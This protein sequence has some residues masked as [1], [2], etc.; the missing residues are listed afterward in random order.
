M[1]AFDDSRLEDADALRDADAL[2]RP[3]AEAGARLRRAV[4]R[5]EVPL[6]GLRA[7]DL[8]RAVIAFGPE[9]RLL[10]A[11]LEPS[12]PVPFV[13]WPRLGLPG[14]AGALDTVVALGATNPVSLAAAKEATRRGARLV[15]ACPPDS[16]LARVSA[17]RSTTLLPLPDTDGLTT[18]IV[19]LEALHRLGLGPQ[20]DVPA[21][22]QAMD[23]VAIESAPGLDIAH[24]PAKGVALEL[25][26]ASPLVWGGSVLAAR[27]SRRVAEALRG[28]SGRMVLSADAEALEPFLR[29][30]PRRDVFA[31]PFEELAP[32]RRPGLVVIDD[33]WGD[34][35][36]TVEQDR[37]ITAALA[38]DLLVSRL[39]AEVG[40]R[41][42]RYVTV[43]H[44]GL[45]AA[46]YLEIGLARR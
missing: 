2:I 7:D 12:C 3:L 18:G 13:A 26:D 36:A 16:E 5:L 46:A 14:W 28:A 27:A 34:E 15:V 21:V 41:V 31:D 35:L 17:S 10:R 30:A 6:S 22:A 4:D 32:Q 20:V 9:A 44:K 29:G 38:H 39:T 33:A 8:P 37:L 43:L 42:Q 11:V 19:T 25:A 1:D 23:D 45:Y 40:G 24:N